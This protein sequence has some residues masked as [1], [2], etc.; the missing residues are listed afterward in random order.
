VVTRIANNSE[1]LSS[2]G[3]ECIVEEIAMLK[4]LHVLQYLNEASDRFRSKEVADG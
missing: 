3:F 2:L 1:M 4:R